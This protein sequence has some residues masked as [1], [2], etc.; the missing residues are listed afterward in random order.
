MPHTSHPRQRPKPI[1]SLLGS[2]LH[3]VPSVQAVMLVVTVASYA[4]PTPIL[5][6]L[7]LQDTI[8][9]LYQSN[10]LQCTIT[11]YHPAAPRARC[12]Q[13]AHVP[14]IGH[15]GCATALDKQRT[16]TPDGQDDQ[17]RRTKRD[18]D[19]PGQQS[20]RKPRTTTMRQTVIRA[21][22]PMTI[23]QGPHR[24]V[25]RATAKRGFPVPRHRPR[26]ESQTDPQARRAPSEELEGKVRPT[27]RN[28]PTG[29]KIH[30]DK[31]CAPRAGTRT[32]AAAGPLRRMEASSTSGHHTLPRRRRGLTHPGN[33]EASGHAPA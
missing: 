25:F 13:K 17:V 9:A 5:R 16:A 22:P 20:Q 29:D 28:T 6:F 15:T 12:E 4:V 8:A 33:V 31:Q 24:G 32:A 18:D 26:H 27:P 1:S 3:R 10:S 7:A 23:S 19:A 21:G 30:A 11:R 2:S 14:A